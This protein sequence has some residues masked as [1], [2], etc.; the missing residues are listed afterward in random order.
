M[1]VC[2]LGNGLS[3]LTLAKALV[4]QNI[5]VEL[6]TQKKNLKIGQSRTLGISKSNTDFFKKN[7]I[8][9]E[10]LLWKLK[11]I[12]IYTDNLK[13]E[14]L[15]NFEN[16]NEQIFSII[17]NHELYKF[18]E[19]DLSKNKYFTKKHLTNKN[20]S[21]VNN[22]GI[23][24]NCDYFHNFTNNYFSKK[25]IK[26]YN[27]IA[28]TTTIRHKKI[29]N[30]I[31]LQIFTKRG[32]LAFLP[33][34]NTE[35]SIVYSVHNS[36]EK[37]NNRNNISELIKKYNFKYEIIKIDRIDNFE[38]K[39]LNLRSY[40]HNNILAFG[41]LLHKIH[42]LAGQGF[43]MTIRDIKV[44][45][46]I[47]KDKLDLGLPLDSSV[48]KE[49]EKNLKHKN[50]IFSNGVDLIHEFFNIERKINNNILSKS[51]QFLGKNSSVNNI[52]TK[53]ADKGIL[54]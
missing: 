29:L 17:K 32:P 19:K 9:I 12:E 35:T 7:I 34:S 11:R 42:P 25:I 5:Y 31:A 37:E 14:K 3:S 50:F 13:N 48:N 46:N 45:M 4:N 53:I 21:F 23:I 26:K 33:I 1:K 30:N 52:F 10:K 49:F 40:Y 28:Y 47:I 2:I 38:L 15:L 22:Y 27:S 24:I 16:D 44:L 43:N 20:L 6:I 54:S 8:N 18:L 39:S 41:D 51:V 36:T